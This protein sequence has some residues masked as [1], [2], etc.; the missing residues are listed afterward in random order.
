MRAS[1]D[2]AKEEFAR[3]GKIVSIE[4][5]DVR[6]DDGSGRYRRVL[7]MIPKDIPI[8]RAVTKYEKNS[9]GSSTYLVIDG[10]MRFVRGLEGIAEFIDQQRK[11]KK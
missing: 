7:E 11:A 6:K 9:A 5:I 1:S 8:Y 3:R 2:K 10:R 4:V